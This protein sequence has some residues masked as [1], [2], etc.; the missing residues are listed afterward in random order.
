MNVLS[1]LFNATQKSGLK[2]R[3]SKTQDQWQVLK[4]MTLLYVGEKSQCER[5]LENFQGTF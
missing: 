3:F 5:Y 4:G 1:K 2:L